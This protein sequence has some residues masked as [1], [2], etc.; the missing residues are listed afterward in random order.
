MAN[1]GIA[2]TEK[3]KKK[4][5]SKKNKKLSQETPFVS[6]GVDDDSE[7]DEDDIL[8]YLNMSPSAQSQVHNT[9]KL[10]TQ[11]LNAYESNHMGK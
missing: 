11:D 3:K 9:D 10:A 6:V 7:E 2:V 1:V 8:N 5:R 4:K